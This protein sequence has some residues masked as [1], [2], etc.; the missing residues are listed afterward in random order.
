M[1]S[2]RGI[3]FQRPKSVASGDFK[4]PIFAPRSSPAPSTTSVRPECPRVRPWNL[5]I[6]LDPFEDAMVLCR[7]SEN[8]QGAVADLVRV[9]ILR[10][11][12]ERRGCTSTMRAHDHTEGCHRLPVGVILS[13]LIPVGEAY[14]RGQGAIGRVLCGIVFS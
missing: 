5:R 3:D 10:H 13:G 11:D 14:H 2:L 6:K 7:V 4:N 8:Q 1:P 9:E 12:G